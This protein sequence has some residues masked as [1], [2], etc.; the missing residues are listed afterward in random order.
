[1]A[2][3]NRLF[4]IVDDE[5]I[6]NPVIVNLGPFKKLYKADKSEDKVKYRMQ[7]QYCYYVADFDS[8]IYN[9]E[10]QEKILK[11]SELSFGNRNITKN[12]TKVLTEAVELYKKCQST[13]ERRTL[14]SNVISCDS[15]NSNLNN[16]TSS[17]DILLGILTELDKEI[18]QST[19]VEN[20]VELFAKKQQLEQSMLSN[21]KAISDLVTKSNKLLDSIIDLRQKA[22]KS[23]IELENTLEDYI[24]DEFILDSQL[25]KLD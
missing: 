19:D 2:F 7:L 3:K 12:I 24:I 11:A 10:E 5:P 6:I 21:A 14:D 16:L 1:M 22:S 8:P 9:I 23:H 17:S 15:L 18:K 25:G 13:V 20:K 4:D